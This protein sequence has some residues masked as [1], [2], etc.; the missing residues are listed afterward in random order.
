MIL[1]AGTSLG[2]Y[3]ILAAIGA[4]GALNHPDVLAVYDIGTYDGTPYVVSELLEG[5]TL[6]MKMAGSRLPLR[7]Y[8]DY[9][10]QVARGDLKPENLFVT[11][12]GRVKNLDFGL[13]AI[14][15]SPSSAIAPRSSPSIS[16][17]EAG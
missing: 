10:I 13:A 14:A 7:K 11:D 8:L 3:Q 5:E 15:G 2:P 1:P 9:A 4:G 12:D 17:L 6:G 16:A